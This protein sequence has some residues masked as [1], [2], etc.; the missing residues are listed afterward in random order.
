MGG[1]QL[2]EMM[3]IPDE[4]SKIFE[5]EK[6]SGIHKI[7]LAFKLPDTFVQDFKRILSTS[8]DRYIAAH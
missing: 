3:R 2:E 4:L 7:D 8:A 1:T 5:A 6:P